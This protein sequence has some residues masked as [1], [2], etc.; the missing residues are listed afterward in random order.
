MELFNCHGCTY[1]QEFKPFQFAWD[2]PAAQSL[3]LFAFLS[4]RSLICRRET[5]ERPST[6]CSILAVV[7][8]F[9]PLYY[10]LFTCICTTIIIFLVWMRAFIS[11][12][13]LQYL[14]C[15]LNIW[16]IVSFPMLICHI[17]K[18]FIL[19]LSCAF[20]SGTSWETEHAQKGL[21]TRLM[22]L[23]L[24]QTVQS[25]MFLTLIQTVYK[26]KGHI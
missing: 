14:H 2:A 6:K 19:G 22:L 7:G 21:G 24:M 12:N 25:Q 3:G 8:S 13:K 20:H 16:C 15:F 4:T 11:S 17:G 9:S 1:M 10:L 26:K 23:I 5:P 18:H